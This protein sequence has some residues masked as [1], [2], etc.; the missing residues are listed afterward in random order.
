[1]RLHRGHGHLPRRHPTLKRALA[2]TGPRSNLRDV[3]RFQQAAAGRC[4]L[5]IL[6]HPS[7]ES[8][9]AE[10]RRGCDLIVLFGGDGTLNRYLAEL[11]RAQVPVLAVPTGSGNDF[12]RAHG[13]RTETEALRV[14]SAWLDG[15]AEIVKSDIGSLLVHDERGHQ[16]QKY[17]ACCANVG[18]DAEAVYYANRLPNWLKARGGYL[19]GAVQALFAY[20]PREYEIRTEAASVQRKRLWFIAVLNTPTYGGGLRIAPHASTCDRTLE[21]VTCAGESRLRLLVNLP[22]LLVGAVQGLPFLT[23]HSQQAAFTVVTQAPARVCADGEVMGFTPMKVSLA[24]E[25]LRVLRQ[26]SV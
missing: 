13:V 16:Q 5:A 22:R 21:I 11:L 4:E 23:F 9:A 26:K 19:I 25:S 10:V 2:V 14:F 3:H 15:D 12:A 1:M 7:L 17:F 18:V 6:E 8:F 24:E 20:S